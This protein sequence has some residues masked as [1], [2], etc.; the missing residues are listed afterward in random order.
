[1]SLT[2][3]KLVVD[4]YPLRVEVKGSFVDLAATHFIFTTNIDPLDWWK[5]EVVGAEKS[6][7]TR[8]ITLIWVFLEI[9]KYQEFT[10]WKDY[11]FWHGSGAVAPQIPRP[12][13]KSLQMEEI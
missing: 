11:H 13:V 8:R 3:F 6:A 4:R 1:M 5:E 7:I 10:S 12:E 9:G 2:D